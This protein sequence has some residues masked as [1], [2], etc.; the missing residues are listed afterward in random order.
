MKITGA[1]GSAYSM[2]EEEVDKFLESKLNLQLATIDELGDPGIQPVWF[3]YDKDKKS[4]FIMTPKTS[5][6]AQN[7]RRKSKFTFLLMMRT[8]RT[9]VSKVKVKRKFWKMNRKSCC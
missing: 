3:E 4:L 7:I 9:R 6:K 8:F 5:K 1:M 2:T